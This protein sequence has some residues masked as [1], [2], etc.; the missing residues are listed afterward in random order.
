MY[1][2]IILYI[3]YILIHRIA[4]RE[5]RQGCS[6]TKKWNWAEMF[7]DKKSHQNEAAKKGRG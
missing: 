6:N 3:L 2:Y 7:K 4:A 5:Q 1:C